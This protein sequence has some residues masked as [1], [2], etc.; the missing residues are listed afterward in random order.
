ME[1]TSL[2]LAAFTSL[3][4]MGT[5]AAATRPASAAAAAVVEA[6]Q[7]GAFSWPVTDF[8]FGS[9]SASAGIGFNVTATAGYVD[10]APGFDVQCG[11]QFG[12][13]DPWHPCTSNNQEQPDVKVMWDNGGHTAAPYKV[14]VAHTWSSA[15]QSWK[16][17]GSGQSASGED[18]FPLNGSGKTQA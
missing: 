17:T 5:P 15:G 13:A 11:A 6:R 12:T 3:S 2:Y 18:D 7:D 9:G 8:S 4:L 16:A 14:Q 1:I 10:G